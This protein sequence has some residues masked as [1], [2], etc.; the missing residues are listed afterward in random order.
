MACATTLLVAPPP[1]AGSFVPPR[2]SSVQAPASPLAPELPE[3][4][5]LGPPELLDVLLAPPSVGP[6]SAPPEQPAATRSENDDKERTA[7][8]TRAPA[9]IRSPYTRGAPVPTRHMAVLP[10]KYVGPRAQAATLV[11]AR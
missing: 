10:G 6:E 11:G 5:E 3:L 1:I 8:P 2:R 9:C 4:P 7:T